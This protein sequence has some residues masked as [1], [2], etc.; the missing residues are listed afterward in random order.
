[1]KDLIEALTILS[2]YPGT[3]KRYPTGCQHDVLYVY[4]KPKDVSKEDRERLFAL[5]FLEDD[6]EDWFYSYRFGG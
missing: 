3:D 4:V 2:K 1:M 6:E 5:G